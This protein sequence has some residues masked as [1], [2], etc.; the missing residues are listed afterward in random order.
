MGT[1]MTCMRKALAVGALLALLGPIGGSTAETFGARV[2]VSTTLND[3]LQ[4][5]DA[6][7][8]EQLQPPLPSKGAGPVRLWIQRF[9]ERDFLFAANHGLA[10]GSVGVFDLSGG[11][12][13]ELPLSPFPSRPGSVGITAGFMRA[14]PSGGAIPVVVVTN[15][16]QALAGCDVPNGSITVFN[17]SQLDSTGRLDEIST[18]YGTVEASAPQP[19]AVSIDPVS[20]YAFAS[21]NCGDGLD[22]IALGWGPHNCYATDP[23]CPEVVAYRRTTRSAGDG[24]DGTVFDT[25]HGLNYTV[26]IGGSSVSVHDADSSDALLTLAL[27]GAGPID[28]TFGTSPQGRA[29]LITANGSDDSISI[30]DRDMLAACVVAPSPSC[31]AEIARIATAVPGGAPEG[32]AYDSATNRVFVVNKSFPPSLSVIQLTEHTGGPITGEDIHQIPLNA[33]GLDVPVPAVI[34]FDV[35]VQPR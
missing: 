29:W 8:L 5:F 20:G 12:A 9:D 10:E 11:L 26:N 24:A 4:F 27:P 22:T 25:D 17:A 33:L 31:N 30:I 7:S 15:A 19:W 14:G 18:L 21:T 28:A 34:A 6:A 2:I 32:V 35:V 13:T 16:S 3:T 1:N 23:L